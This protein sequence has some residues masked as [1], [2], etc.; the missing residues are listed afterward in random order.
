MTVSEDKKTSEVA[1]KKT[2][3]EGVQDLSEGEF[4]THV[5]FDRVGLWKVRQGENVLIGGCA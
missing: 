1:L 5:R 3:H 2:L 4:V